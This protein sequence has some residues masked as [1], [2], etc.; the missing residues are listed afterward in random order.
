MDDKQRDEFLH[1]LNRDFDRLR[2]NKTV[3]YE[4]VGE[5]EIWN[6]DYFAETS[7]FGEKLESS[8]DSDK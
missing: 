4:E 6:L 3:W 8:V 2:R 7:R 5:R 1:A